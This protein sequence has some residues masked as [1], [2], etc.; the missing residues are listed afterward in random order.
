MKRFLL[1]GVLAVALVAWVGG[2]STQQVASPGP[3]QAVTLNPQDY[4]KKVDTFGLVLDGSSSMNEDYNGRPKIDRAKELIAN[5]LKGQLTAVYASRLIASAANRV[6]ESL[7]EKFEVKGWD[8]TADM[9]LEAAR[10]ALEKLRASTNV[11]AVA[12]LIGGLEVRMSTVEMKAFQ[13]PSALTE[14]VV[15]PGASPIVS[16]RPSSR[17]AMPAGRVTG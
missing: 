10:T 16:P 9:I 11:G 1:A 12:L 2:C 13:G 6:G 5:T 14:R 7:G 17:R 8:E 4:T 3:F 15:R